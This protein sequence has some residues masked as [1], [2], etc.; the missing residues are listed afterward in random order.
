MFYHT[1]YLTHE[2]SKLLETG[3]K[4][5]SVQIGEHKEEAQPPQEVV[6]L[7]TAE[8]KLAEVCRQIYLFE[9]IE[10]K[11]VM[12]IVKRVR[13]LRFAHQERFFSYDS[14]DSDM[15]FILSGS[16]DLFDQN[17]VKIGN[18]EAGDILG[19][20]AFIARKPRSCSCTAASP[21]TTAIGFEINLNGIGEETA[22]EFLQLYINISYALAERL[23]STG[24][25][26]H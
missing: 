6:E 16:A 23:S 5:S 9:G 1:E 18:V 17:G 26:L 13:L 8:Q 3:S 7:E 10:P 21:N 4:R 20:M 15:F 19:E 22:M 2:I 11:D 14:D 25:D 12:R 24:L